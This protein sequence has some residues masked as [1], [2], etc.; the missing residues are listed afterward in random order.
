[1]NILDID[2][3]LFVSQ[4]VYWRGRSS[5]RVEESFSTAWSEYD[6]T[7]YLENN[8][9]LSKDKKIPG[10]S[11]EDHDGVFLFWRELIQTKKVY[12]PFKLVHLD[13]HADLGLGDS[14]YI[15]LMDEIMSKPVSERYFPNTGCDKMNKG[16][17]LAFALACNWISDLTYVCNEK[18][19]DD[20][21]TLHFKGANVETNIIEIC[22]CDRNDI[23]DW[24]MRTKEPEE[25][26]AKA[27]AKSDPVP[28]RR[29][30]CDDYVYSSHWDFINLSYSPEF[31]PKSSDI[32]IPIIE[33]YMTKM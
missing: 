26:I 22:N 4:P 17:F 8:L 28:F 1:M 12:T 23:N 24:V 11:F 15:Y 21:M 7:M 29:I 33:Q 14:G 18:S 2:L 25:L 3:D 20:L 10:R 13:S 6:L 5:G 30:V 27:K 16:N 19:N 31:T 32:L 9:G